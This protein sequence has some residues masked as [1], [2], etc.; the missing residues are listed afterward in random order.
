MT[1]IS[2]TD[3]LRLYEFLY[4][5]L[6]EVKKELVHSRSGDELAAARSRAQSLTALTT[7]L[8]N[9]SRKEAMNTRDRNPIQI[10]ASVNINDYEEFMERFKGKSIEELNS[11]GI[12]YLAGSS[13]VKRASGILLIK[14]KPTS[15]VLCYTQI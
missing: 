2:D 12:F 9:P 3:V 11:A 5:N 15:A 4:N 13:K 8:G 14:A 6:T 10:S 1:D 7:Q